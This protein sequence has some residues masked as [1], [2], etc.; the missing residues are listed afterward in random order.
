MEMQLDDDD[1]DHD[2]FRG[3]KAKE[4]RLSNQA[5]CKAVI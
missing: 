3:N 4:L 2:A 1:D 5:I